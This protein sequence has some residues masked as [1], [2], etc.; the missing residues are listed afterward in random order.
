MALKSCPKSNKSPNLVTLIEI[1]S[2]RGMHREKGTGKNGKIKES[3]R[4]SER[5]KRKKERENERRRR[6]RK[7]ERMKERERE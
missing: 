2:E 7:R 6:E 5:E 1:E 3:G 4:K